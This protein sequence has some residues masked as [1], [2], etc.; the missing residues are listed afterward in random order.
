MTIESV[1]NLFRLGKL[2]LYLSIDAAD[3]LRKLIDAEKFNN[4]K[5]V[6]DLQ[7]ALIRTNKKGKEKTK[8]SWMLNTGNLI[9]KDEQMLPFIWETLIQKI[10]SSVRT[11]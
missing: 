3:N 7:A 11:S 6:A 4:G 10:L 8:R 1:S 5:P 2:N 9:R